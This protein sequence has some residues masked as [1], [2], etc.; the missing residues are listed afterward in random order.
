MI[1][2]IFFATEEGIK[3]KKKK[4]QTKKQKFSE[5]FC[6]IL[7]GINT[8]KYG[9]TFNDTNIVIPLNRGIVYDKNIRII[10]KYP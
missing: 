3:K 2:D 4:K 5:Q 8:R 6:F 9:E 1:I 10:S 7:L